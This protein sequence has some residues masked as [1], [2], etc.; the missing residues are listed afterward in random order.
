MSLLHGQ[1]IFDPSYGI[2]PKPDLKAWAKSAIV[3]WAKLSDGAGHALTTNQ[4][5][6]GP[7]QVTTCYLQIHVGNGF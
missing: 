2:G 3:A 6:S 7:G 4:C 5:G 1:P